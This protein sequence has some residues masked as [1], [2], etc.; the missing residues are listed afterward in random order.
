MIES[1][2][3]VIL[4]Q[5]DREFYVRAGGGKLS[6]DRGIVDLDL[7]VGMEPGDEIPSHLGK[8]FSVRLPRAPDFF[9]HARRSGAPMLP[10]DIGMVIGLTGMNHRDNVLDAGTGSGIAAIFFGGVAGS[11]TTFEIREEFARQAEKN[12]GEAK[13]DNVRAVAGDM[14]EAEGRFDIVHLDL[15]IERSHIEAAYALLSPGGYLATYTP[16]LEQTFAVMDA[17]GELFR[18]VHTHELIEREL[19]RTNRGTRPS[20]RVC[21]TGYITIART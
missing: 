9:T 2:D 19:T 3:R 14:R 7:L 21:H 15:H 10:K 13:L 18:E 5:D 11:V 6:T 12:I 20:T 17:A 16:F 1:N 8:C 4:L